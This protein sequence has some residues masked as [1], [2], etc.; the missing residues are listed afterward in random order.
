MT[1]LSKVGDP[2]RKELLEMA[3]VL[4]Q[5]ETLAEPENNIPL[6]VQK[7]TGFHS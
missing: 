2:T 3:T 4:N 6:K 7:E 5:A 1:P